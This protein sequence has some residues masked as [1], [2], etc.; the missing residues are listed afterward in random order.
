MK[1][2]SFILFLT[3]V[4][5]ATSSCEPAHKG[6]YE[7]PGIGNEGELN[8]A[9]PAAKIDSSVEKALMK[10]STTKKNYPL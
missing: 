5:I 10:D 1:I 4:T 3:T 7:A 6:A 2:F 8:G 9:D